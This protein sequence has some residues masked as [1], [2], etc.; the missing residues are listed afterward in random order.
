ME[1]PS[2][3]MHRAVLMTLFEW[4]VEEIKKLGEQRDDL[5]IEISER[6]AACTGK[7]GSQMP[8]F[9]EKRR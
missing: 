5:L 7:H 9:E 8:C 4:S 2:E 1:S 3:R 6:R